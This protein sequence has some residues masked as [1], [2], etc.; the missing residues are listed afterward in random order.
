[1]KRLLFPLSF[2]IP[3]II[4]LPG[5]F[6]DLGEGYYSLMKLIYIFS[7]CY[8]AI[9]YRLMRALGTLGALQ[10]VGTVV[11]FALAILALLEQ[12][13][14]PAI[15]PSYRTAALIIYFLCFSAMAFIV[16][17]AWNDADD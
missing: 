5:L 6:M 10:V 13:M 16:T 15:V 9:L 2:I 1:M 11:T 7:A 17:R 14:T 8:T 12:L 4:A 3:A